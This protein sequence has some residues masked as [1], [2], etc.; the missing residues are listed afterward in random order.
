ML[1][2]VNFNSRQTTAHFTLITLAIV[3]IYLLET[4]QFYYVLTSFIET[5]VNFNAETL[6]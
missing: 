6:L 2:L 5:S 4:Y 3:S 1:N